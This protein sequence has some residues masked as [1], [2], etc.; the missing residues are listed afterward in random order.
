MVIYILRSFYFSKQSKHNAMIDYSLY[1]YNPQL[2]RLAAACT[3]ALCIGLAYK[4]LYYIATSA[5]YRGDRP[6]TDRPIDL[7]R[8]TH[9]STHYS[10]ELSR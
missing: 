10:D 3:K 8:R 4:G 9:V 6:K 7:P 2:F 5:S 1:T